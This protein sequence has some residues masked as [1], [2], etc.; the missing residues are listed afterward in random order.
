MNDDQIFYAPRSIQELVRDGLGQT[1]HDL[2][3]NADRKSYELKTMTA[4]R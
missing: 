3:L 4:S 1:A 2:Q